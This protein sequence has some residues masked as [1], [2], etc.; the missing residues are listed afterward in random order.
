M[1]KKRSISKAERTAVCPRCLVFTAIHLRSGHL[2]LLSLSFLKCKMGM[3]DKGNI[4]F[5]EVG[6]TIMILVENRLNNIA[7]N[8]TL[9]S[10]V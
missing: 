10:G 6:K 9:V 5:K 4:T 3:G 7:D 8:V 1:R 2:T